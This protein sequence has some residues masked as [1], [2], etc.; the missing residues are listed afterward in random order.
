MEVLRSVRLSR[1]TPKLARGAAPTDA[2]HGDDAGWSRDTPAVFVCRRRTRW[3]IGGC[4]CPIE[5]SRILSQRGNDR[6]L[7]KPCD[8]GL[9]EVRNAEPIHDMNGKH[10]AQSPIQILRRLVRFRIRSKRGKVN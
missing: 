4:L 3:L 5:R 8:E 1:L 9:V 10:D 2:S 7:H 6:E